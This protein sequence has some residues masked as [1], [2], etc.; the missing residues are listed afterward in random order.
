MIKH[1]FFFDKKFTNQYITLIKDNYKFSLHKFVIFYSDINTDSMDFKFKE[2]ENVVYLKHRKFKSVKDFKRH[3]QQSNKLIFHGLFSTQLILFLAFNKKILRNSYWFIWG[4]DLYNAHWNRNNNLKSKILYEFRKSVIKKIGHVITLMTKEHKLIKEWYSGNPKLHLSF[5]Y[6]SN[7]ATTL[8]PRIPSNGSSK[9]IMLGHS[10]SKD[11]KHIEYFEFLSTL[12]D[13]KVY[14]ILSYGDEDYRDD[15]IQEGKRILQDR[16]VPITNYLPLEEYN[17]LLN[18]M[19]VIIF[20]AERQIGFGNLVNLIA[21][22]K[23]VYLSDKVATKMYFD[24]IG[25]ETYSINDM[26]NLLIID[27]EIL[28][29]NSQIIKSIHNLEN[30]IS[31]WNKI[32]TD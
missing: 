8:E 23:K 30:L 16:F 19:D 25:V 4:G 1:I 15:V 6:P 21:L 29:E 13:I 27:E 2:F 24:Q 14:S 31:Q 26:K 10:S 22:G 20:P 17:N 5:A 18:D 9:N 11:N 32:F 7:I 3:I 12:D 28:I